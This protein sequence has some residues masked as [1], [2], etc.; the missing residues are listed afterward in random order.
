MKSYIGLL[1]L[2]LAVSCGKNKISEKKAKSGSSNNIVKRFVVNVGYYGKTFNENTY[3]VYDSNSK[4]GVIIDP[5]IKSNELDEF[6]LVYKIRIKGILN[7]HGHFDHIGGNGYYK[8]RYGVKIY[9]PGKDDFLYNKGKN[10]NKPKEY[11]NNIKLLS[12]GNLRIK[13]IY[14]PGHTPGSVCYLFDKF[15]FTGDTLFKKSIGRTWNDIAGTIIENRKTLISNIK[16]KLLNLK[17]S[18]VVL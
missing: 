16:S 3:V 10:I 4:N 9:A 11:F 13:L 5:G 7:T 17:K 14:T 6:V 12:L 15:V 1:V 8:S 18:L 2:I